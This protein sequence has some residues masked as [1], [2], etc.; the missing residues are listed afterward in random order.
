MNSFSEGVVS[1]EL[2]LSK[3]EIEY[4]KKNFP[5]VIIKNIE[6]CNCKDKKFWVQVKIGN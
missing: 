5:K 6:D 4:I 3:E 1:R 2:R